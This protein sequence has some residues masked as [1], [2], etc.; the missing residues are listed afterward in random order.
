MTVTVSSEKTEN[1]LQLWLLDTKNRVENVD[2]A[3]LDDSRYRI[4]SIPFSVEGYSVGDIVKGCYSSDLNPRTGNKNNLVSNF[5]DSRSGRL[6]IRAHEDNM[7][8]S[9]DGE[10]TPVIR[11]RKLGCRVY[12]E[13][14]VMS[15]DVPTHV[16]RGAFF[17]I[18][19]EYV[20]DWW[21]VSPCYY[22]PPVQAEQ[23]ERVFSSKMKTT[24]H[25]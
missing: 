15:I 20:V 1:K 12:T 22:E 13:H 16:C 8:L 23:S 11:F 25:Q 3:N 2:V 5:A 6:L 18:L 24:Q 10:P 17:K 7:K 19:Q 9:F 21:Q 4:L 14:T